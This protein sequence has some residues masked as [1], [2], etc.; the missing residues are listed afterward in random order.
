MV[1][2]GLV[3][4]AEQPYSSLQNRFHPFVNGLTPGREERLRGCRT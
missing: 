2:K 1:E 3:I 4:P